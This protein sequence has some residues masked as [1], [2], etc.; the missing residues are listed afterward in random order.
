MAISSSEPADPTGTP[1]AVYEVLDT[2]R[3]QVAAID[4]LVALARSTLRVFDVDL[5]QGGWSRIERTAALAALLRRS[6]DVRV[7]II[8]H[9]TRYLEASC[10]RLLGL[11]RQASE[12]MRIYRTGREARPA[13]DPLVL[14]DGCHFLHRFHIDQPRAALGI[15]QPGLV[16]PLLQRFDEIWATGEPGVGASVLGL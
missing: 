7:Q 2:V 12:S 11:L 16:R 1:I 13:M 6:R 10:P 5:S 4:R 8:V 9:D 14:V 15:E 3:A